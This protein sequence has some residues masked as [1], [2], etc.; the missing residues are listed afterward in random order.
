MN[1]FKIKFA[2]LQEGEDRM[3]EHQKCLQIAEGLHHEKEW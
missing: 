1:F 3:K 2:Q